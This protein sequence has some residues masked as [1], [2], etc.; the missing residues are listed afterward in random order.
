MNEIFQ[1][2]I[3]VTA[4]Y[5][6][7]YTHGRAANLLNTRKLQLSELISD[8][9]TLDEIEDAF[10]IREKKGKAMIYPNI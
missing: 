9:L 2:E 5:V 4:S 6:N 3:T 10:K 8:K 1:R 7:P